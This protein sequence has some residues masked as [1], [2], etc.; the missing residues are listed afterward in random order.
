MPDPTDIFSLLSATPKDYVSL[1]PKSATTPQIQQALESVQSRIPRQATIQGEQ[2]PAG[3]QFN[4]RWKGELVTGDATG[5]R[6]DLNNEPRFIPLIRGVTGG[7][8]PNKNAYIPV[9]AQGNPQYQATQFDPALY[10]Q[11][12]AQHQQTQQGFEQF[13]RLIALKQIMDALRARSLSLL[14]RSQYKPI[15]IAGINPDALKTI[16]GLLA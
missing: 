5:G 3:W 4:P 10:A 2:A 9:D 15:T 8:D 16:R 13:N 11:Q 7:Y 12:L 6:I 14:G 1:P